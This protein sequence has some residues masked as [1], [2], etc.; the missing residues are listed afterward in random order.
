MKQIGGPTLIMA[1]L[2]MITAM[3]AMNLVQNQ[4][5]SSTPEAISTVGAGISDCQGRGIDTAF[6]RLGCSNRAKTPNRR[7]TTGGAVFLSAKTR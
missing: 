7:I 1:S 6:G 2:A 4:K 3:F 5:E